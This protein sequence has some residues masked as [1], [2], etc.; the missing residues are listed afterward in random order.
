MYAK[1]KHI[2]TNNVKLKDASGLAPEN[3][4]TTSVMAQLLLH[5]TKEKY[6]PIFYESLPS[7]NGLTMKS[8]YIGGT[9]S[10]AGYITLKDSTKACFA[11]IV[12]DYTCK[13][14]EVKLNMFKFLDLLK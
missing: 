4:I 14:K 1:S 2:N 3:R 6:Y 12:N 7:I 5:Y 8:G 13:P 10:Y 11:F 9:R